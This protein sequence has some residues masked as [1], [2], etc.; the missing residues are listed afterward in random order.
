MIALAYY[1]LKVMICSGILSF[2]Y[3]LALRNKLFHQWNRFYLLLA[4]LLSIFV[5]LAEFNFEHNA[6]LQLIQT[7]E[8][9]DNYV[10]NIQAG[11]LVSAEQWISIAYAAFSAFFLISFLLSLFKIADI[12]RRHPVKRIERIN[13]INT[14]V[15]GTPF[16]FLNYIFWN[17]K[18]DMES[19]SGKKIYQHELV[20]VMEKHTIDKLFMQ[21]VLVLFWLN[22]FFWLIRKE[23]K[24]IHEFIADKKA[25][26]QD[27]AAAFAAL[28][29]QS[30]YPQHFDHLT[31][32]FFQTSIKRRLIML[33][34]I[35]HPKRNY[36][37]RVLILPLIAFIILAFSFKTKQT[38]QPDLRSLTTI[39]ANEQGTGQASPGVQTKLDN[40]NIDSIPNKNISQVNVNSNSK[41]VTIEY[42][43]GRKE[44]MPIDEASKRMSGKNNA[45]KKKP[46]HIIANLKPEES[47]LYV[48]DGEIF[49]GDAHTLDPKNIE[50]ISVFKGEQAIAMYGEKGRNGV[51]QII[52]KTNKPQSTNSKKMEQADGPALN[53]SK[54][55]PSVDKKE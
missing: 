24:F 40:Q 41:T 5:P 48:L 38:A 3:Y 21:V 50:S 36:I 13:F 37:S 33:T 16:S 30:A 53:K 22:P 9:A 6:A 35:N 55:P 4:V 28:I 39:N 46:G 15:E 25:F 49:E 20:H 14:S 47:P 8:R 7:I 34:K 32:P 19:S 17:R 23:L 26:Q 11:N 1:L 29:L 31:N 54:T 51:I 27:G 12:I 44:T 18:I 45:G 43:D 52:S 42:K 10:I 2:Y